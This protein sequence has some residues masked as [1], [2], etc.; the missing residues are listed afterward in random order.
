MPKKYRVTLTTAEREQLTTL[1]SKGKAAARVLTHARVLLKTDEAEGG[2]AWTDT[3]VCAALDVGL[4]TVMRVRERFVE[5]GLD[6]ALRPRPS[7]YVQPRKLDGHLEAQLITLACSE[8]PEG[9]SRWTL[10]LLAERFVQLGHLAEVSHET[11]RQT[12]KKTSSSRGR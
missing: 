7:S 3:A 4:C 12:L 11:I 1:V 8:A 10:R 9:H 5:Q 6:A 2:P